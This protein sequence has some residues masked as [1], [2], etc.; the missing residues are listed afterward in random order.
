MNATEHIVEL[1][2]QQQGYLTVSDV[3][4]EGTKKIKGGY[5]RQIDLLAMHGKK[6]PLH[7]EI[8]ISHT[9]KG[10]QLHSTKQIV[11]YFKY[12]FFGYSEKNGQQ[13]DMKNAII[14]TYHRYKIEYKEVERVYCI[15]DV[16]EEIKK[17]DNWKIPLAKEFHLV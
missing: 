12:K 15:W 10:S 4:I 9:Q 6:P 7:I 5:H 1:Y 11:P 8:S 14:R 2:F 13:K 16:D 3:K 17:S